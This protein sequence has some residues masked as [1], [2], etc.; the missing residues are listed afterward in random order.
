MKNE[1]DQ[2]EKIKVGDRL[3]KISYAF[4]RR[5]RDSAIVK[6]INAASFS[7]YGMSW[8]IPKSEID[9]VWFTSLNKAIDGAIESHNEGIIEAKDDIA[10]WEKEIKALNKIKDNKKK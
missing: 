4:G 6:K 1:I 8:T 10:V 2:E 3:Y 7:I 5:Y 9:D